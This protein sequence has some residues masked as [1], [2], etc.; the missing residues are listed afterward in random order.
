VGGPASFPRPDGRRLGALPA[1][2][3]RAAF[4]RQWTRREAWLKARGDGLAGLAGAAAA[5]DWAALPL[6]AGCWTLADAASRWRLVDL[7]VLPGHAGALVV[8]GDG[9]VVPLVRAWPSARDPGSGSGA[10][11]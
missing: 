3:A 5:A 1:D 8:E 7:D 10:S 4:F 9:P 6:D 11:R 2:A